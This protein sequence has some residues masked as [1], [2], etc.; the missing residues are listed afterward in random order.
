MEESALVI[1]RRAA[2]LS[3]E[4]LAAMAGVSARTVGRAEKQRSAPNRGT[5][6]LLARA[7]D[8]EPDLIDPSK[9]E[10]SACMPSA[11]EKTAGQGPHDGK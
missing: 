7:L 4:Q 1:A 2:G 11:S 9:T 10:R 5:V 3:Q 8:V 6:I